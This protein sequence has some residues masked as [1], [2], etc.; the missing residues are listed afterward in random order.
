MA[1]D[2]WS[3]GIILWC[4]V[5]SYALYEVPSLSDP[6]FV[7]LTLGKK[8]IQELLRAF[9]VEGVSDSVVDLLSSML[10]VDASKRPNIQE[11]L[12]HS[13]LTSHSDQKN[14][15]AISLDSLPSSICSFPSISS[16]PTPMSMP[17]CYQ[18]DVLGTDLVSYGS[19]TKG[20]VNKLSCE[21]ASHSKGLK[22]QKFKDKEYHKVH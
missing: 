22:L 5:T 3:L 15:S 17:S 8:G 2:I 11:V 21:V 14:P 20:L 6:R 13:F 10:N 9:K 19:V 16:V 1:A 12:T 7:K 18:S 4:L